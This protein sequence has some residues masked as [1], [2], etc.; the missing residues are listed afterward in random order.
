[1]TAE[2]RQ[3]VWT[4]KPPIDLRYE[5]YTSP[6]PEMWNA[7]R[8]ATLGVAT[9]EDA[10]V[11]EL[12]VEAAAL[13]GHEAALLL[14][15]VTSGTI[16]CMMSGAPR[17][18]IVL[19]EERCHIYWVEQMHLAYICGAA[20]QLI[21]GDKFGAIPLELLASSITKTYYGS[22]PRVSLLCLENTHNVCGGTI[23]SPQY[24]SAAVDLCHRNDVSVY[25]DGA[26]L[27]NAAVALGVKLRELT[28]FLDYVVLSLSKGLGAPFGAI[29]CGKTAF[30]EEARINSRRLG[31]S[32]LHRA[33]IYAAAGLVAL[34]TMVDRLADDHRRARRL[35]QGISDVNGIV[36]DLETV[37]TNLVRVDTSRAGIPALDVVS[38]LARE[39][40]ASHVIEPFAF[41]FA[42]H[43]EIDDNAISRAIE[44]MR[45]VM[46]RLA[47]DV[48]AAKHPVPH[49]VQ[50]Q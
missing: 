10:T 9:D 13:A 38:M 2:G 3:V 26:R 46:G 28:S 31:A 49:E 18:S 21:R 5:I 30:I 44:A 42:T 14:P 48:G 4:S 50:Q 12:E 8:A 41:K 47:G 19:M 25:L 27:F 45:H 17:G 34:R 33:G 15:T 23:L 35:A 37:Q 39:G 11:R 43:H 24:L 20:P 22:R 6:T 7:M 1:M 36:V 29:L 16:L 32:S 40:I